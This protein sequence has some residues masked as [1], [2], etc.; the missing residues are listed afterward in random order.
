[1]K[2]LV[3]GGG[4]REHALAWKLAQSSQVAELYAAP[5]NPGMAKLAQCVPLEDPRQILAFAKE[6]SIDLTVVGPECY[7][8]A[9][10]GDLF[11]QAGLPLFGPTKEAAQLESSKSFAKRIC[12][13]YGIPTA[14]Y[15][16]VESYEEGVAALERFPEP[17]VVKADG[18]AAG[19]GVLVAQS[20]EEAKGALAEIFGGRFGK[21]G[22]RV[23]LEEFLPGEEATILAFTD[24]KTILPMVP[25]QD[26]KR[27]GEGD[28]GPNTGGMGAYSPVPVVNYEVYQRTY[29]EIFLP[30]LEGLQ[31][32]G[33]DYK[34]V[35]YAGLMIKD[36]QPKV[37]E[38]NCR[39]G[40]PEAQVILPRLVTD[41]VS[42]CQATVEG[43]LEEI[44][45]TW[46]S[47][48][49]LGVVIA[50]KGYPGEFKSGFPIEGLDT[51]GLLFHNGTGLADGR[52]VTAGGRVI[53][54]VGMGDT[55]AS[56][57]AAA[58]RLVE[59]ISFT[60]AYYRSDIGWRA[61]S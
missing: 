7:L 38:F 1:M 37:V 52:I 23:V 20:H 50:S 10:I 47:R 54:A 60:G 24:G 57:Q 42:I 45:L 25:A 34:G 61:L 39:F 46:D 58:Y 3:V 18:L 22:S 35:I 21:A 6:K 5:G 14:D 43:R 17:P 28:T 27:I 12:R 11:A 16:V 13:K 15:V 26:H 44:E 53:T 51:E 49:A 9:G 55:L 40:D 48:A 4:G 32:E 59:K 36:N 56:A 30:L 8:A 33:I 2:V 41:L 29:N 19:K 31:K